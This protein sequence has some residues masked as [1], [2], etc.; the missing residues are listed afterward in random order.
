M[1]GHF[2]VSLVSFVFLFTPYLFFAFYLIVFYAYSYEIRGGD[3]VNNNKYLVLL[4]CSIEYSCTM[5][6]QLG[7]VCMDGMDFEG[8]CNTTTNTRHTRQL[9]SF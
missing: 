3:C 1:D 9:Q 6:G 4:S 2:D 7:A 8:H 5:C